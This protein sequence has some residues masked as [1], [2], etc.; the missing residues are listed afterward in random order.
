[1]TF[2]VLPLNRRDRREVMSLEI[3]VILLSLLMLSPVGLVALKVT[4]D[5]SVP[6]VHIL[7]LQSAI[8]KR[9]SF[10][11]PGR[12][13]CHSNR[14]LDG[15][16]NIPN[17][18]A[19][20]GKSIPYLHDS[21]TPSLNKSSLSDFLTVT[22]SPFQKV[23]LLTEAELVEQIQ[24]VQK[25]EMEVQEVDEEADSFAA[26]TTAGKEIR[27]LLDRECLVGDCISKQVVDSLN[28]SHLLF[29]VTTTICSCFNNQC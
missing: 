21:Y 10:Q 12:P 7:I 11:F 24:E 9:W 8:G 15:P 18:T 22:I 3:R 6:R 25:V 17:P 28:A 5:I 19:G 13:Y 16:K 2:L 26:V 14:S 4:L 29:D 1:M 27:A 23:L 20:T